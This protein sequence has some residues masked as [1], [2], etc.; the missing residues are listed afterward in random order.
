MFTLRSGPAYIPFL[1]SR[2]GNLVKGSAGFVNHRAPAVS[3]AGQRHW[4]TWKFRK[5]PRIVA[6][7]GAGTDGGAGQTGA[8]Q[9]FGAPGLL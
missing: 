1:F 7:G 5:R 3:A 6:D 8:A 9:Q 2:N 4:K